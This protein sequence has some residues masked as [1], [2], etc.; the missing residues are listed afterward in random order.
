MFLY[1][2]EILKYKMLR[3]PG[4]AVRMGRQDTH[5]NY[6][7]GNHFLESEP[8]EDQE[9]YWR[10]SLRSILRKYVAMLSGEVVD[11]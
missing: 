11:V 9:R 10:K 5:T 2:H 3:W 8:M 6:W 4:H 7:C 1:I